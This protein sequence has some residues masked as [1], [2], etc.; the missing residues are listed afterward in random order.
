MISQVIAAL[1]LNSFVSPHMNVQVR[2]KFSSFIADAPQP[3]IDALFS[4]TSNL[5]LLYAGSPGADIKIMRKMRALYVDAL[6]SVNGMNGSIEKEK[7]AQEAV[8]K[9]R[10]FVDAHPPGVLIPPAPYNAVE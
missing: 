10:E 4:E 3:G 6:K 7:T 2:P 8:R 9:F 1:L 5:A